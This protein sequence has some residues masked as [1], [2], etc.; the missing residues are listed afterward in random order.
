MA[1]AFGYERYLRSF[2]G[3]G[4]LP[5]PRGV[6][7]WERAKAEG[8]D[9][10]MPERYSNTLKEGRGDT[11]RDYTRSLSVGEEGCSR[12]TV[13]RADPDA[14]RWKGSGPVERGR[15]G[16]SPRGQLKRGEGGRA[17]SG[18]S[19]S[20][21]DEGFVNN[22]AAIRRPGETRTHVDLGQGALPLLPFFVEPPLHHRPHLFLT[23]SS[24]PAVT[25]FPHFPSSAPVPPPHPSHH[26]HLLLHLLP[27]L[28]GRLFSTS[29]TATR[30]RKEHPGRVRSPW[31]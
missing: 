30:S 6:S 31:N 26:L 2:Y 4:W 7:F 17:P 1:L 16:A 25:L 11:S 24:T 3:R 20:R 28:P 21:V 18:S 9:P 27:R 29:T 12:L 8:S 14:V 10:S 5:P 23:S 13:M 19:G 15:E 22:R